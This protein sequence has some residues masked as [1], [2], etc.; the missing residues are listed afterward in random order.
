MRVCAQLAFG[1][2]VA[3]EALQFEHRDLHWGNVLVAP[4]DREF[5]T[6]L[7]RGRLHRVRR[8]GA[9]AVVIDYSLSRV[10]LRGAALYADL[11]DDDSLF[12]AVGDRQFDVYRLMRDRLGSVCRPPPL[13]PRPSPSPTP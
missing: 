1:L 3:E 4:S 13:A 5:A 9:A 2:A 6:F 8:R 7:V 10:S 12:D 11:A